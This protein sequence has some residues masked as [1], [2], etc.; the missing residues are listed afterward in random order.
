MKKYL[1]LLLFSA[2]I[3]SCSKKEVVISGKV[4]NASPLSRVE[5]IDVS[6]VA[7]LPIANF[8]FDEK[9]NFSDTLNI[10]KNGVYALI[11]NGRVGSIY[12]KKGQNIHITGNASNFPEDLKVSGEGQANNEFLS[13]SQ[14]F[15]DEYLSKL[16]VEVLKKNE[17]D[18]I[19]EMEKYAS[20]INKK[21]D[22]IAKAKKADSEVVNWKK[23]ELLVNLLMIS[24]QYE[25]MH[26]Q[27]TGNANFKVS[28]KFKEGQK[29]L[30]KSSFIKDFPVFRQ[31]Y[32]AKLQNDF[33]EFAKPY[34]ED[35]KITQTE[36]FLKFLDTKKEL[37]QETKDYLA[38]FVATQFDLHPQNPK[39]EQA[40]KAISEKLKSSEIK[41]ELEKVFT[42][43]T[44]IKVGTQAPEGALIGQDGKAV[45]VADFKGKP[46][47]LVFYSSFATGMVEHIV[48]T[49][50]ELSDFYKSKMN[51]VYINL[52]DNQKQFQDTSKALMKDITGV[53]LYAKGGLK[54]EIAK[55]YYI[56][57]FKLPSFIVLDKEGKIAS[58]AFLNIID[59]EFI[60]TLNKQTGL[61]APVQPNITEPESEELHHENDGHNH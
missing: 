61:T 22:E 23:D 47:L 12:L 46:T 7:T 39:A 59:S 14:K 58:K 20:D 43:I 60:E 15:T 52:D 26:G 49:L 57:G 54:S 6:S 42:T 11:Y 48:P 5:I 18:F 55:Q 24:T 21:V 51:F 30:E 45:K 3:I 50:K 1:L 10:E 38:S 56:Y 28:D 16:N 29:K 31:Y 32:L 2:F 27:L 25:L 35:T 53:N 4:N 19:K 8:G 41:K 13:E 34:L 36:V 33:K 17:A 40:Y 9:G 37:N 44:G